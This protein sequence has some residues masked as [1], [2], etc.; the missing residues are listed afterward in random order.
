M[1]TTVQLSLHGYECLVVMVPEVISRHCGPTWKLLSGPFSLFTSPTTRFYCIHFV[2]FSHWKRHL[3][4]LIVFTVCT[5]AQE[6]PMLKRWKSH[7]LRAHGG[8]WC[9]SAVLHDHPIYTYIYCYSLTYIPICYHSRFNTM[10]ELSQS[11]S[12]IDE[13]RLCNKWDSGN[14]QWTLN[15]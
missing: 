13:W 11:I 15:Q 2:L 1:L 8:W 4:I 3:C 9:A 14:F 5:F 12:S 7:G 10:I 6:D